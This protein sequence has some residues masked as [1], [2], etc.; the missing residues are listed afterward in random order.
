MRHVATIFLALAVLLPATASARPHGSA[1]CRYLTTQIDFFETRVERAQQLGNDQWGP[2]PKRH[3]SK[4]WLM[5][6][7]NWDFNWQDEYRL[8]EPGIVELSAVRNLR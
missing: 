8:K 1:E 7:K 5:R 2:I 3:G 4:H 6:M